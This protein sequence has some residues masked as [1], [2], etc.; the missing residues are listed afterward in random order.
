M[1]AIGRWLDE[2]GVIENPDYMISGAPPGKEHANFLER[3]VN[4]WLS[5]EP[6]QTTDNDGVVIPGKNLGM[7]SWFIYRLDIY[8]LLQGFFRDDPSLFLRH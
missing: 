5:R 6:V 1:H 8:R 7:Q 4:R 2:S 3:L